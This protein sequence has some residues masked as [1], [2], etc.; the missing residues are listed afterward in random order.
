MVNYIKLCPFLISSGNS[1]HY[2]RH[3]RNVIIFL[4]KT[5]KFQLFYCRFPHLWDCLRCWEHTE[6]CSDSCHLC[7]YMQCLSLWLLSSSL[8]QYHINQL[9]N[10]HWLFHLIHNLFVSVS[11]CCFTVLS[12]TLFPS[13]MV[14]APPWH[15]QALISVTSSLCLDNDSYCLTFTVE[16][17]R[18][19]N[20]KLQLSEHI[21]ST[22]LCFF[23]FVL[24]CST[25]AGIFVVLPW[26]PG[27][28]TVTVIWNVW[29]LLLDSHWTAEPFAST[30]KKLKKPLVCLLFLDWEK[31]A[32]SVVGMQLWAGFTVPCWCCDPLWFC[33]CWKWN[34]VLRWQ[35][36]SCHQR[37][38][39][40][41][42][43]KLL[44]EKFRNNCAGTSALLNVKTSFIAVFQLVHEFPVVAWNR[45]SVGIK[46]T[47]LDHPFTD[48][49]FSP[50]SFQ[51]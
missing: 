26:K 30:C 22:V 47:V 4:W 6:F 25:S 5:E 1:E 50:V 35:D 24:L 32:V 3:P 2:Q 16:R 9:H 23:F 15:P 46:S 33:W 45:S 39:V 44:M 42:E 13:K 29:N 37:V 17:F 27:N 38:D 43:I 51:Y 31:E 28:V 7:A 10:G 12:I 19:L 18:C 40:G 49:C 20:W 36:W 8:L 21:V 34:I 14:A 48:S 41:K 11:S